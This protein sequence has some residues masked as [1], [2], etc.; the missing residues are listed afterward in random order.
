MKKKV[1]G[2]NDYV[3]VV[4]AFWSMSRLRS[5]M[6]VSYGT[7]L[8]NIISFSC[9]SAFTKILSYHHNIQVTNDNRM[10]IFMIPI[11]RRTVIMT[12]ITAILRIFLRTAC[13]KKLPATDRNDTNNDVGDRIMSVAI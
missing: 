13:N 9:S 8:P 7:D 10:Q 4:L 11:L 3:V 1:R 12:T 6:R 5:N 2:N